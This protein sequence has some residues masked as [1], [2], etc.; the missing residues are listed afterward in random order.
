MS[1]EKGSENLVDETGKEMN[2]GPHENQEQRE[3]ANLA[4]LYLLHFLSLNLINSD[5]KNFNEVLCELFNPPSIFI[6]YSHSN[7]KLT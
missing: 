1:Q 7:R 6:S 3:V 2:D 5:H 4:E